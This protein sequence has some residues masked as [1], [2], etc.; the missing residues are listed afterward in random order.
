MKIRLSVVDYFGA[1]GKQF[2]D[3]TA[4]HV[5]VSWDGGGGYDDTVSGVNIDLTVIGEGHPVK[6]GHALAL[7]SGGN[8]AQP[9]AWDVADLV[10]FDQ[11]A[12]RNR[13]IA[14]LRSS[15]DDVF[16]AAAGYG[17][18]T[19][20]LHGCVDDLLDAVNVGCKGSHNDP[21][22]TAVEK[23]FKSVSDFPLGI[24]MSCLFHI[25]RVGKKSKYSLLSQFSK[26][27]KVDH[28]TVNGRY[29]DLEIS[30]MD[31]NTDR[32]GDRQSYC[33]GNAVIDMDQF[34]IKT[35]KMDMIPCLFCEDLR[36]LQKIPLFQFQFDDGVGQSSAV[37]RD[38]DLADDIRDGADM[39]LVTVCDNDSTDLADVF[40]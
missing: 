20:I 18:F 40:L 25:G 10:Q 28:F 31:H 27:G 17:D 22:R 21:F 15:F 26:T 16:H 24:G 35:A 12:C 2:I 8:D 36:V 5:F 6:S 32:C 30:C 29:I 23:F 34:D 3:D 1:L 37:N 9:M 14:K 7:T 33:V 4:D 38:I 19:L 13:H 11:C 39:V